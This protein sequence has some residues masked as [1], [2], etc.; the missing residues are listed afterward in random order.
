MAEILVVVSRT[1][2]LAA[3]CRRQLPTVS[4]HRVRVNLNPTCVRTVFEDGHMAARTP[5][6]GGGWRL[7]F[8][9]FRLRLCRRP[10]G[11]LAPAPS[12]P[13]SP[14][15]FSLAAPRRHL[16]HAAIG[17]CSVCDVCGGGGGGAVDTR[18][19]Q[20]PARQA[21]RGL[22]ARA[23]DAKAG[24]PAGRKLPLV[25]L[26]RPR[27]APAAPQAPEEAVGAL[28]GQL[29]LGRGD[30]ARAPC[31]CGGRGGR[32]HAAVAR[33]APDDAHVGGEVDRGEPAVLDHERRA[34]DFL[35]VEIGR[36][37]KEAG[38]AVLGTCV[39]WRWAHLKREREQPE[40]GRW[41]L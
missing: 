25:P 23:A 32:D 35:R 33:G 28:P 7:F 2:L 27:P 12:T 17:V 41:Y 15:A 21:E 8:E 3:E 1:T 31:G 16:P 14:T 38:V 40:G 5:L 10:P 24:P 20:R 11:G 4:P 29:D 9:S 13:T 30:D 19:V 6:G 22:A 26:G 34:H 36:Q 39:E 18:G 37:I